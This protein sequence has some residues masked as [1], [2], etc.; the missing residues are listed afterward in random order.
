MWWT[1][2]DVAAII[3]GRVVSVP[4]SGA[5]PISSVTQD[6]REARPGSLFVPLVCERDGHDFIPD[7]VRAGACAYLTA[8]GVDVPTGGRSVSVSASAEAAAIEVD[9]T[10][11]ALNAMARAARRRLGRVPVVGVTGSAG[12]TTTKDLLAAVLGSGGRRAH[13]SI[14]SFNNEIGVPLTLLAAPD[15]AT[16]VVVEM[17]ARGSGHIRSL[18]DIAEPVMG[19]VTTVGLA[20]TS[21]F[22]SLDAVVAA[23]SELVECLPAADAGG[24][25]FLNADVSEVASMAARTRARVVSY[26]LASDAD[27]T[28]RDLSMDDGLT[29]RFVLVSRLDAP[30]CE[31]EAE[32]VLG[33]RGLHTVGNSLAAAAVALVLG[34]PLSDAAAALSAPTLS[35]MR[36]NLLRTPRGT[37]VIDDSYNANPLSVRAALRALGSLSCSRR[38]AVLGVMAELGSHAAVEHAAVAAMAV[39][40]GIRVIAVDAPLYASGLRSGSG[41]DATA[42]VD[43]SG[44][45]GA[46][47]ALERLGGLDDDTC[48]LV[49]GSRV[50]G[51]ERL[52]ERIIAGEP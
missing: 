2:D 8:R 36:M 51:L 22:G 23:K 3:G 26:G 50:A 27:V 10:R 14:R 31:A 17:G 4:R 30:A 13:A 47:A 49:K 19:V 25:A 16:A 5:A 28:A 7:A 9:D 11:R 34:V 1:V 35:P 18:C 48:V 21:Q 42:V 24:V 43:A 20:H 46:L 33:A 52:V 41:S 15:D 45:D 32:V 44:I 29:P 37:R 6:S 38:L 40:L 39:R 12:K